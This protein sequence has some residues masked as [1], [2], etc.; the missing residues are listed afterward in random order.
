MEITGFLISGVLIFF[1]DIFF[2]RRKTIF[3]GAELLKKKM[4]AKSYASFLKPLHRRYWTIKVMVEK[5]E[6]YRL[7]TCKVGQND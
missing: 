1:S 4:Y 5:K 7:L 3:R 6:C 2:M